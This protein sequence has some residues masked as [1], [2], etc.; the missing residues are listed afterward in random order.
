LTAVAVVAGGVALVADPAGAVV[1]DFSDDEVVFESGS[2]G[3]I[4]VAEISIGAV[5]FSVSATGGTGQVS[6]F[7]PGDTAHLNRDPD[8]DPLALDPT[9]WYDTSLNGSPLAAGSLIGFD[10]PVDNDQQSLIVQEGPGNGGSSTIPDDALGG[11]LTFTLESGVP[12]VQLTRLSF[13]DDVEAIVSTDIGGTVATVGD[14][15]ING[16]NSGFTSTSQAGDSC[17]PDSNTGGDNCVAGLEFDA[18]PNV[19]LAV[20]DSFKVDFGDGSGAVLGFEVEVVPLPPSVAM[21]G[22]AL[23]VLGLVAH[24]RRRRG[25]R[26]DAA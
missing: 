14:I 16:P 12:G 1:F 20:G 19:L 15:L 25:A 9:P 6:H 26:A 23:G 2:N 17:D 11:T 8:L 24:R 3:E 10:D 7:D 13:V 21:L 5:T 4:G 22:G 18:S